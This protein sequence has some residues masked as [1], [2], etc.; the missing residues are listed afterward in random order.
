MSWWWIKDELKL[1]TVDELVN[2]NGLVM[3]W[4]W[5]VDELVKNCRWTVKKVAMNEWW[6]AELG[7]D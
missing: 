6:T 5:I 4:W 1:W 7:L 2:D 3:N